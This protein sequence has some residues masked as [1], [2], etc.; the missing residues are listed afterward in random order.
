MLGVKHLEAPVTAPQVSQLA[1]LEAKLA[2]LKQELAAVGFI[3]SGSVVCR[4]M[5]CGKPGCRCQADPPQLHGPYWQWT[6]AVGG[7]TMTRRLTEEQAKL[8][9][10]WIANRRRVAKI[11]ADMEEVSRQAADILL[12]DKTPSPRTL[13]R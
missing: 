1:A 4:Y 3:T 11:V 5:P 8:Y 13:Q 6:R 7:K 2:R 12:R 9:Q 10:E